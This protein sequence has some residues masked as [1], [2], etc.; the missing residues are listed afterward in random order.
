MEHTS[1]PPDDS[2]VPAHRDSAPPLILFPGLGGDSRLFSTQRAAFP[3]LIVPSWIEP[4]WDEPLVDYA[5]RFAKTIDPGVPCFLGGVSFGGVVALEVASRLLNYEC[6]LIG[7]VRSHLHIPRRLRALRPVTDLIFIPKWIGSAAL[8]SAGRWMHPLRCGALRQLH[9]AD[10][11]FLRWAAKAI[12]TWIPSAGVEQV[13]VAQ[14]HGERDLIFPARNV[15][16]D[17]TVLGA[18]HLVSLTHSLQ[19]NQFL[20]DRMENA[21][22]QG[23]PPM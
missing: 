18:G 12:L 21:L 3:D 13:R 6:Y 4:E 15:T 11:R 8:F 10:L 2:H 22:A 17:L 23:W 7:S 16:A 19:V 14:I 20:R 5:A 1:P 9:E